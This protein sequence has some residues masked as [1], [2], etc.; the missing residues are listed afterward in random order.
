MFGITWRLRV[1]A[2]AIGAMAVTG[3]VPPVAAAVQSVQPVAP[4]PTDRLPDLGMA[5]LTRFSLDTTS[6]PGRRLLR[7]ETVIVNVGSGPF[8]L[9]GRRP[10]PGTATMT[11]A[12]RIYN[13]AGGHRDVPTR[14]SMYFAGDGHAHWHVRDLESYT[15]TR[16][17]GGRTVQTGAKHGFCFYDFRGH[18]LSLKGA[19]AKARYTHCGKSTDLAVTMGLSVGWADVY[20]S[21]LPDQY[22][23]VT[24]LK[25]GKYRLNA[26]AD[27]ENWFAETNEKNNSTWT[28]L[29]LTGTSVKVLSQGPAL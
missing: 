6:V 28:E 14:A 2:I 29:R 7:F 17:R 23:D 12:Q 4:A 3:A 13:S 26:T 10:N 25:P 9:Q 18:Q 21:T 16:L 8:Q 1:A 15:L 11:V 5:P 22:L 24:G 20:H 19:P 27:A